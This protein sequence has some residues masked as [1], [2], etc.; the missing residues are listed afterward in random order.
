MISQNWYR[1]T[2]IYSVFKMFGCL[3]CGSLPFRYLHIVKLFDK[4]FCD[5]LSFNYLTDC[6]VCCLLSSWNFFLL[7][8]VGLWWIF[9]CGFEINQENMYGF[10]LCSSLQ[11]LNGN[12]FFFLSWPI[13]TA[14]NT[15]KNRTNNK[16]R[17]KNKERSDCV[18]LVL[19]PWILSKRKMWRL[20]RNHR[21]TCL[22]F[23]LLVLL[24]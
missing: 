4:F 6:K 1:D 21:R 13:W 16:M 12:H 20:I 15:N 7:I 14:I 17:E 3:R 10:P 23:C 11:H 24:R 18:Y 8:D 19:H 22:S 9:I 5:L 2:T